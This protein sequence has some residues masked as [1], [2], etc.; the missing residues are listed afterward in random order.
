MDVSVKRLFT[1]RFRLGLF[2]PVEL[3]DYARI[4]IS[5]LECR[6]HQDLAKQLARESMVLLKNDQLLPLQKNKLKKVVVMGPNADSR[7]SLLGNYNGNPS[8]MLTPL[9][10]IRE[11]LGGWTE[12]EYIEGVDHVNTISADD[13]KQYVNRAKGA[14]AVIFIG[15]ISR[16]WKVK[17]CRSVKTGSME[18]TAPQSL[19]LPFRLR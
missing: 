19:C 11:R 10:A 8:R 17:K 15:G 9:Q 5:I 12:V 7:E 18:A 13:L 3:V 14:D 16:G 4:P 6:K 1:I 2:D